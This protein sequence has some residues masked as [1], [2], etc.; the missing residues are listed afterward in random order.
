MEPERKETELTEQDRQD[1]VAYLD[2]ELD[3]RALQEL[4]AKL[5]RNDAARREAEALQRTWEMLDYLPRPQAPASF[6]H[7]TVQ[8]LTVGRPSLISR[9]RRQGWLKRLAWPAG[10][11]A[12]SL[13]GFL[14]AYQ[15]PHS[16]QPVPTADDVR[17]LRYLPYYE[18]IDSIE[19]LKELNDP[20][21]FGDDS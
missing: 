16:Q 11:A 3:P 18:K 7:Q 15:W 5:S 9:L 13:L 12:A 21:L 8:K 1:L 14:I 20:E 10:A 6:T 2:G 19:F 17:V 4:E